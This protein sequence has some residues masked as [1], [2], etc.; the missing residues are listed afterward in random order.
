MRIVR[1]RADGHNSIGVVAHGGIR[2][3]SS[4]PSAP[5]DMG[6]ALTPQG[7]AALAA[8]LSRPERR[9]LPDGQFQYLP[10]LGVAARIFCVGLNFR[11]HVEETGRALPPNPS[12]FIRTQ[13]SMGGHNGQI[14]KPAESE[15]LDYECE[16]AVLIGTA[17]R[18]I[19]PNRAL[20]HVGG[21]TCCNDGSVRDYQKQS[22]SA[23]KNF[24]SS[25]ALGPW[26]VTADEI[27][28]P[29]TLTV[30]T[31]LNGAE[32]QRGRLDRL[33]YTI[34]T[35]ISYISTFTELQP[36]DVITTGT[37]AGVGSRRDPQVWMSEGDL[38][39]IEVS[40][41]GTL[42]STISASSTDHRQ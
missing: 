1:Y 8:I 12:V 29:T 23:G 11:D 28:D 10:P 16:V 17:G 26:V 24:D 32:M 42:R 33:I 13:Q 19:A 6:E 3:I 30:T 18:R 35:I 5:T 41:I 22:V 27:P 20:L 37:P 4:E 40:V 36:G 9:V 31:R 14:V 2:E 15:Q 7:Q 34:P 38:L 39:E 25:G 21:Y